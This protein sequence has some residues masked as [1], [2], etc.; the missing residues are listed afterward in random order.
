VSREECGPKR[1]GTQ[2]SALCTRSANEARPN[3]GSA[4][5]RV[6]AGIE[7]P[8]AEDEAFEQYLVGL[9][10]PPVNETEDE[11]YRLFLR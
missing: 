2:I 3:H 11:A 8:A 4:Y 6:L 10:Y 5:G 9:G 1:C 7:V